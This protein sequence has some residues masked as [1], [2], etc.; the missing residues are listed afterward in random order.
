MRVLP[1]AERRDQPVEPVLP[2]EFELCGT[3]VPGRLLGPDARNQ[4]PV[5]LGI[6]GILRIGRR[7][8]I[9]VHVDIV[10]V[11]AATMRE[12]P[13]ID[14]VNEQE[15]RIRRQAFSQAR[16]QKPGLNGRA[17]IT[18]G[19]M[20]AGGQRQQLLRMRRAEPGD[21]DRE[22]FAGGAGER[23]GNAAQC[24]AAGH[25]GLEKAPARLRIRA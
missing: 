9:A 15:R 25:G 3:P 5:Q 16:L 24:T 8:E 20:R 6:V 12:A 7:N 19:A 2:G 10:F 11:H 18:L 13:G 23:M 1:L 14:G 17:G 21:I 4:S 22:L